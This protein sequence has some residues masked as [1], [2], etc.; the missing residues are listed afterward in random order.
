[1]SALS[2]VKWWARSAQSNDERAQ[3]SYYIHLLF[4][5]MIVIIII[6]I[7]LIKIVNTEWDTEWARPVKYTLFI[8]DLQF[9]LAWFISSS[10]EGKSFR[11][12]VMCTGLPAFFFFLR[13]FS[14][15]SGQYVSID[16]PNLTFSKNFVFKEVGKC[17]KH[18]FSKKMEF[19]ENNF[20]ENL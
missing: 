17:Q 11:P 18:E 3:L 16:G 2:P 12:I 10:R 1:M 19:F 4:Y 15:F 5:S 14:K 9:S 20:C 13:C 6:Y 8:Y 7:V